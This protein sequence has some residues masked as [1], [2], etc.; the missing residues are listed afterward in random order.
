MAM[1]D[2]DGLGS[3]GF[4]LSKAP[5]Q[6]AEYKFPPPDAP[7]VAFSLALACLRCDRL[8]RRVAA[9]ES[10]AAGG[11]GVPAAGT[12]GAD[13]AALEAE[14]EEADAGEA[15]LGGD[16]GG[17]AEAAARSPEEPGLATR[18]RLRPLAAVVRADSGMDRAFL[19]R[20]AAQ[21]ET[22]CPAR[23]Q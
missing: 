6:S 11:G 3:D 7:L 14:E 20:K 9:R 16:G 10:S 4:E 23:L 21:A 12:V 8:G 17:R 13:S 15:A 1:S 22:A 19:R 2:Q 5:S 18:A